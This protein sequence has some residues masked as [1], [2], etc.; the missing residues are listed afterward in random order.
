MNID[1]QMRELVLVMTDKMQDLAIK[2]SERI[3]PELL[4]FLAESLE[5]R[6]P[7]MAKFRKLLKIAKSGKVLY[8]NEQRELEKTAIQ[9]II[10]VL[11]ATYPQ[12]KNAPFQIFCLSHSDIKQDPIRSFTVILAKDID[13]TLRFTLNN[14]GFH[15]RKNGCKNFK[16]S[17]EKFIEKIKAQKTD[18]W[19]DSPHKMYL[20]HSGVL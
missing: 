6:A 4:L 1:N 10:E 14:S 11:R 13:N 5:S 2:G 9:P 17:L 16:D 12:Y 15:G 7:D 3:T 8:F 19:Y 20:L 18:M